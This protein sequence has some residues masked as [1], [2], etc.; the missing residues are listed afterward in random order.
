MV[1]GEGER[2]GEDEGTRRE[3]KDEGMR[4]GEGEANCGVL[5]QI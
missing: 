3:G 1:D 5:L 4:R 2:V